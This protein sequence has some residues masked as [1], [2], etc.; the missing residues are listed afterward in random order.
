MADK[1]NECLHCE[2]NDLVQERLEG[3]AADLG[4]LAAMVAESLADLILL[5]RK[6][7]QPALMADALAHFGSVFI[8]KSNEIEGGGSGARH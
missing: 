8:E 6:E 3:R 7:D 1:P 2:I 4:D 5:A